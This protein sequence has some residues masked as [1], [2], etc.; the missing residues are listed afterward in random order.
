MSNRKEWL[1]NKEAIQYLKDNGIEIT[2]SGLQYLRIYS[3]S[4]IFKKERFYY[5]YNFDSLHAYINY[6]KNIPDS[7]VWIPVKD[8]ARTLHVHISRIYRKEKEYYN[9]TMK[10]HMGLMYVNRQ[11]FI[12]KY[13]EEYNGSTDGRKKARN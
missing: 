3:D 13:K 12:E 5:K 7:K 10:T 4:F 6:M 2:R 11:E 1:S 9:V 8:L